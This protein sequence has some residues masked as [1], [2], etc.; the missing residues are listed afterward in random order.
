MRLLISKNFKKVKK[1]FYYSLLILVSHFAI[2]HIYFF[3]ST[4]STSFIFWE[5]SM[6]NNFILA[7]FFFLQKNSTFSI[8]LNRNFKKIKIKVKKIIVEHKAI[9]WSNFVSIEY[10][11]SARQQY[12][13]FELN[14]GLNQ[15]YKLC[16]SLSLLDSLK[17]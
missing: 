9:N 4:C 17:T 6:E 11:S 7:Y 2:L 3:I 8:N 5:H 14:L 12:K 16:L 15:A 1:N 13:M 10:L